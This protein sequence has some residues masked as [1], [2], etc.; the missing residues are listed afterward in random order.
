MRKC[1]RCDVEMLDDYTLKG[2]K[3]ELYIQ[4]SGI[5]GLTLNTVKIAVCPKC[6][7]VELFVDPEKIQSNF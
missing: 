2:T 5:C 3:S 1:M 6:G 7:Q 4:K